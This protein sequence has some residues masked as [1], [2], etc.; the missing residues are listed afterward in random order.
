[1]TWHILM[2][3]LT[4]TLFYYSFILLL[5]INIIIIRVHIYPCENLFMY[6]HFYVKIRGIPCLAYIASGN[7]TCIVFQNFKASTLPAETHRQFHNVQLLMEN[8]CPL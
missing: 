3:L 4:P 8:I 2:A 7:E 5:L 1:M 6:H